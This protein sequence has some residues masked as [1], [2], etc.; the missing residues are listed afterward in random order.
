ML[1]QILAQGAEI[2]FENVISVEDRGAVKVI[3]TRKAAS[4]KPAQSCWQQE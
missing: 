4:M 2:E 1:D 3:R